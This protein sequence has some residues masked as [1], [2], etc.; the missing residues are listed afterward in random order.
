[1]TT[2][3][4]RPRDP[5]HLSNFCDPRETPPRAVRDEPVGDPGPPVRLG[6]VADLVAA[7]PSLLGF[8]PTR[9]LVLV[10][11]C[12]PP[13]RRIG[14]SARL[15]LPGPGESAAD[16]APVAAQLAVAVGPDCAAAVLAVVDDRG[17][18]A[19]HD[20]VV[21][22]VVEALAARGVPVT[23]VVEVDRL[24]TGGR[25]WHRG[26][27][28]S[29]RGGGV[30]PDPRSSPV[31]AAH[32]LAGRVLHTDREGLTAVVRPAPGAEDPAHRAAVAAAVGRARRDRAGGATSPRGMV[33]VVL[34]A[35]ARCEDGTLP[36][37]N[38]LAGLA[39]AL[40]DTRVRDACAGLAVTEHAGAAEQLW[41]HAARGLP[42]PWRA[43][44][45]TL[46]ALSCYVRGEGPSA[47]IALDAALESDPT[48]RLATML[49]CGLDAAM[50]PSAARDVAEGGRV[51]AAALGVPV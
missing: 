18:A 25:W 14:L 42:R 6:G 43:E 17:P 13:G 27:R 51:V 29:R 26:P 49:R 10:S 35:V 16:L 36:E 22:E 38:E 40:D 32:V 28:G 20:A 15:D 39:A 23:D 4:R 33:E 30:L 19:H 31:A 41:A 5:R 44:P 50:P 2:T 46:L 37:A 1:M 45:A 12:G 34:A 48:H 3:P 8:V 21:D 7:V 24:D 11:L 9:S 47:G